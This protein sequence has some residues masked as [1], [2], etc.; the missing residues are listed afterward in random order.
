[1]PG[2]DDGEYLLEF[3]GEGSWTMHVSNG[4]NLSPGVNQPR[5]W[6]SAGG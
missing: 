6:C 3:K 5:T 4:W 1:M 2:S